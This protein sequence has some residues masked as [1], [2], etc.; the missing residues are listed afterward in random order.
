MSHGAH[1]RAQHVD[2][3]DLG[4]VDA[5]DAPRERLRLDERARLVTLRRAQLL[6]VAHQAHARVRAEP[7]LAFGVVGA[8]PY[9]RG[10]EH[11]AA[12]AAAP[13]LVDAGLEQLA[14]AEVAPSE[15][16]GGRHRD[17]VG[18]PRAP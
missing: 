11:R 6:R 17:A 3:V 5:R 12:Q 9:D 8:P 10:R 7:R 16:D 14:V 18:R 13:G 15:D 1:R 4:G 2:P